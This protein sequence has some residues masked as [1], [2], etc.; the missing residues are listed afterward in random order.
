MSSQTRVQNVHNTFYELLCFAR[1][2]FFTTS[3]N[4]TSSFKL[5]SFTKYLR[6]NSSFH[7][8]KC[9]TKKANIIWSFEIFFRYLVYTSSLLKVTSPLTCGKRKISA[10]PSKRLKILW[11][12]LSVFFISF[13]F[14]FF[15]CF[16]FLLTASIVKNSHILGGVYFIFPKL[17][18]LERL[19]IANVYICEKIGKVVIK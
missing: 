18:R 15:F 12:W 19:S 3:S 10:Q 11:T 16:L 14:F 6:Q 17:E 7:V 5:Q 2:P 4:L 1:R 8:R 9:I 13:F